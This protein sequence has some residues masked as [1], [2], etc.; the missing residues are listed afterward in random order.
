M[1]SSWETLL[2]IM[3]TLRGEPG[4][5]WDKEQTHQSLTPY[6]V[7]E[8]Y[9]VLEAIENDEPLRLKEELGDLLL[10]IVFHAQIAR[11]KGLFDAEGVAKC[12]CEKMIRRHPHV[13]SD[14]RVSSPAEVVRK[15]EE[16]KLREKGAAPERN[17]LLDGIPASLPALLQAER[18]QGRAS[19]VG[20]DWPDIRGPLQKIR[21]ESEEL[22]AA[23]ESGDIEKVREELG[24]LLFAVVNTGRRMGVNCEEALR[25]SS[26]KFVERFHYLEEKGRL[27]EKSLSDFNLEELDGFWNE[28]KKL[29]DPEENDRQA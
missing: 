7:E 23:S 19:E 15:W 28:A 5:P 24:D 18:I 1:E 14:A 4:C 22:A 16:I 20:F 11:E 12:I 13:F 6:L 29:A 25:L 2:G 3:G 26:K 8:T 10:Q 9:E 21:E 17:S 27:F